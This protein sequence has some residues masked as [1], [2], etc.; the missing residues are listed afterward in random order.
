MHYNESEPTT[1]MYDELMNGIQCLFS[2]K[3]A[4]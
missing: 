3:L 2:F 1:S 4:V